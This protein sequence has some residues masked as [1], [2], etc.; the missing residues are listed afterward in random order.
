VT[1]IR[2]F[3]V[4]D[5]NCCCVTEDN[6]VYSWGWDLGEYPVRLHVSKPKTG[7]AAAAAA[8]AASSSAL[9]SPKKAMQEVKFDRVTIG[10]TRMLLMT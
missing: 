9:P 2:S 6:A 7:S 3:S 5:I 10:H 8:A 1:K 4:R